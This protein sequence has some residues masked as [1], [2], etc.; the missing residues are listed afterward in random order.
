MNPFARLQNDTVYIE[1]NVGE[2]SAPYKTAIGSKGGL[3]AT[4]FDKNV[5]VEE[6][7]KL[8]RDLPNNKEESYTIVEV[9]FSAG[10]HSIPASWKLKL[11]KDSSLL[12]EKKPVTR[13]TTIN[14]SN[15]QGIQ[16]GDNNTQTIELGFQE[17]IEKIENSEVSDFEKSE[18]KG[19]LKA[20]MENP[21]VAGVLGGAASGIFSLLS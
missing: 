5:N 1:N 4:I 17:L 20:L 8:I 19:A 15:S 9:N 18:A 21:V 6:G 2:R 3:S 12:Q 16:V 14:I 7:W 11:R 13:N 10:L